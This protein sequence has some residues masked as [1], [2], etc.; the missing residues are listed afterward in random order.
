M[1]E[2]FEHVVAHF[3]DVGLLV[4]FCTAA[5]RYFVTKVIIHFKATGSLWEF[6]LEQIKP[7]KKDKEEDESK[8]KGEDEE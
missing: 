6:K 1:Q 7:L 2:T 3:L 4:G 5:L 8:E